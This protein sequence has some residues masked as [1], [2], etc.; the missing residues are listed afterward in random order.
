MTY[1]IPE[2]LSCDVLVIG[3]GASG[4]ST[5]ITAA[6][7]GLDV[8]VAEKAGVFGGTSAW[9]GGWLWIPQNP[10]AVRA[11]IVE[12]PDE[13]RRYLAS[14]LG[15]RVADPRLEVFLEN[16][17]EMVAFF[18]NNTAVEWSDG[19]KMP[20]FHDTPGSANGGRS[21]SAKPYDGRALGKW[22]KKLRPPLNVVSLAGMGIA[23]GKD[24]GH[25]FNATRNLVSAFYVA[26]RLAR[27]GLDMIVHRRG[28]QLVNGNA[29]VAR[30]M[31]SALDRNVRMIESAPA[32]RLL[33]K[34]DR[35]CGAVLR[36]NSREVS[37]FAKRAVVLATGGF[38]HDTARI[39][40]HFAH[41]PGGV[42]HY[43]A[44]PRENT[45]DGIR[46][47][48]TSGA[49]LDFDL[50]QT[51]ALA[52]V[53]LVRDGKNGYTSF[54][55]L[56]ERSKPG[57]IAVDA[58]GHRFVNE[59][60]SYHDFIKALLDNAPAGVTPHA[61]LICDHTAQRRYGLGWAR[62]FPFPVRPYLRND[63]MKRAK[64]LEALATLCGLPPQA[65]VE[66]VRAFNAGAIVGDDPFFHR[67]ASAYNRTQ[68]AA[69]HLP[70]PSLGPLRNAPFYAVKILPGSLGTFAG[71]KTTVE[72][73]AVSQS[74]A[75]IDGLYAVGNDMASIMGG[76]YPSGGI[77]L[78]P[79]MTFGYVIGRALGRQ[80]AD[81]SITQD[82]DISLQQ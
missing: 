14:E 74:G 18:E 19:N 80:S 51:A 64:S 16:G 77:T 27:H 58:S 12:G 61:W 22:A 24:M 41:A 35:V 23:G 81:P 28:M 54:P 33:Q 34:D 82:Q 9:S 38:P 37:V 56:V 69:E 44:A 20:D 60:D 5:A 11:G 25:F 66:T 6:Y 31:R 53:S 55:H 49:A 40:E 15:N 13:P 43:S 1:A 59:A 67:G 46:L 57:F 68:G 52:P 45:G 3:S 2:D 73:Q 10:L 4:L 65:L 36:I 48:E 32:V 71:I 39:A 72:G 29:L 30:L 78:G 76:N 8:I 42:G 21:V 70:N 63:Y 79:G 62:P 7:H 75:P 47:A 26:G 50:V 17:P